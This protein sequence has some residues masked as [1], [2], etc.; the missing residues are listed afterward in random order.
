MSVG[1]FE[2]ARRV[3][4]DA[5]GAIA[6][7]KDVSH[8][9]SDGTAENLITRPAGGSYK[10]LYLQAR[11]GGWNIRTGNYVSKELSA[12]DA[13]DDELTVTAHGHETGDGP[14]RFTLA[15]GGEALPTGLAV[16]TD[17]WVVKVDDNTIQLATSITNAQAVP[18]SVIDISG[19]I[20]GTPALGGSADGAGTGSGWANALLPTASVSGNGS[21]TIG[22]GATFI[23]AGSD[24]V[25]V[26]A[27][28]SGDVLTYWWA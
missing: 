5:V 13:G 1:N 14:F 17:Y 20:T 4:P 16:D 10:I 23:V 11:Q 6:L 26:R 7:S 8:I 15:G 24:Q 21:Q 18:A 9:V 2:G 28:T 12:M 19:S 22:E 3:D 25:S 27:Y